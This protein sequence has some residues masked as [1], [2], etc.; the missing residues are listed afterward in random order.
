MPLS[1]PHC[2]YC[3]GD[4]QNRVDNQTDHVDPPQ[5]CCGRGGTSNQVDTGKR[6]GEGFEFIPNYAK[7]D[8]GCYGAENVAN[9]DYQTAYRAVGVEVPDPYDDNRCEE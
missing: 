7:V 6:N 9:N 8:E 3:C 2:G 4:I 1:H 5:V